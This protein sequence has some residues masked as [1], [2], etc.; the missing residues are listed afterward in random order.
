[1][2]ILENGQYVA[3]CYTETDIIPVHVLEGCEISLPKVFP[4]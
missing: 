2:F 4:D 3:K 1:V